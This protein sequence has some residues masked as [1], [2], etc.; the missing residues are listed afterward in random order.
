MSRLVSS[1]NIQWSAEDATNCAYS[2]SQ[3]LVK[4]SSLRTGHF[5]EKSKKMN[6]KIFLRKK[7]NV[8]LAE[9]RRRH[10]S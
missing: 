4:L 9:T 6:E 7:K 10:T 1:R 3:T 2:K 5:D 8:F